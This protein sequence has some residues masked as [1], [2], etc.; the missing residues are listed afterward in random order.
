M[1]QR[2]TGLIAA[3]LLAVAGLSQPPV[4]AQTITGVVSGTVVDASGAAVPR[5]PV[6]LVNSG[7]GLRQSATS[8]ASGDFV[9]PSV[10]PGTY[11]VIVEAQGF[12]RYERTG[13]QVTAAERV[14][15]GTIQLDVGALT[16][17]VTVSGQATPVQTTSN[18]R[19]AML[20]DQQM[21]MLM[22][23]GRD[24]MGLMKTLP[25]VVPINDPTVLQQTSAPNAVNGVRG[26][27]T[28]QTVDGMVG[29]DPSSTNSSFTPVSMDAVAE[30]KVLLTNYQ[31]EYGRSAGAIINAVT[32]SG[33][34]AFHGTLYDYVRNEDLNANEF[35]ANRNGVKR[36]LYRYNVAGY[37]IGGP[38][39]IP[40]KFTRWKDKLFFFVAQEFVNLTAP[41]SLQQVTVP[42][43]LERQGDF[44]QTLDVSGKL[45]PITD[46]LSKAVFPGNLVP[47]N[48]IDP[49]GQKLLQVFPSPNITDR[50][51]TKGNY[52]Y[53]FLESIPG[54]RRFDTYRGDYNPVDKLRLYYR[55]SVFRRFD[56]GY[57]VAASG[58]AW[59][60]VKGFDKYDSNAGQ[61]HATYTI[62]STLVL[63]GSFGYYHFQEPAGPYNNNADIIDRQKIGLA[64]GQFYPQYNQYNIVPSMS[65]G[66]GTIA[67]P[68]SVSFDI[69][70]PKKGA[71]TLFTWT[72]SVTKIWGSHQI[73]AGIFLERDRMFKG[74]RGAN[75]G[76]F[77]FSRDVNNP[78]DTN[79]AYSTALLGYFR[80]YTESTSRPGPDMRSTLFEWYLQDSWRVNRKLTLDYG[81]RFGAYT[82]LWTPNLQA[83][84][85]DPSI[86][87]RSQAPLLFQP[88]LN[89]Q[90][91][92][93]ALNPLTGQYFPAVQIGLIVP[94]SGNLTNGL[95]VEG[96]SG[97]PKGFVEN[98][99]PTLAPRFGFA[100]DVFGD[101]KTA[102]RG[103][104]GF[105]YSPIVP[106]TNIG[107]SGT[108]A[109]QVN[110]PFQYNPVQYYGSLSTLFNTQGVIAPSTICGLSRQNMNQANYNFSFGVQ[111]D[112]GFR[113]VL[114]VA[115]VGALGR[116]LLQ[117][118]NLNTV[119][120]GTH[121]TNI[122]PTTK[123]A[124]AD[125]FVRPF[126]GYATINLFE[127]Y[128]NSSY[129]SMQVQAN[130]RFSK[131]LQFG[132]VWTWS[133]FM[134]Y[135]DSDGSVVA[136]YLDR[137]VWNYGKAGLDRTHIVSINLLYDVPKASHLL[138]SV[139][140]RLVL[141][142]WQV[143]AVASFIDGA[144]TGIG[145]SL[146]NGAD[147][148]G[149]GDGSRV[150]VTGNAVLDKGQRSIYQY[151]NTGAFQAP[152]VGTI[153]N[154]PKDVFRGPGINNWDLS[155]FKN[156]RFKDRAGLQLRW[157][158]YNA[159]NHAS[160]QGVNTSASFA[161]PG[162]TSQLNG[163]FGQLT[164]TNGQP[165][166]M[167]GS[168]RITF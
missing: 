9:F 2:R 18:E 20:N 98:L 92:R 83:S 141:D 166:A 61:L 106:G 40:G 58:P 97:V 113:T 143:A 65:F 14:N 57:A 167:Q 60:L 162:A 66:G 146:L 140:T 126:P 128:S 160:F 86:Y 138:N 8:S 144:P 153:G 25:G 49:N 93:S 53:N 73:K 155:F 67:N 129:H 105:F 34:S 47:Q 122:D 165:R 12:K 69:R 148:T 31:A 164:S 55:E 77:D 13:V 22:A 30:V 151:F 142:N 35:F 111:R 36:P 68:A 112:I 16:E 74:F 4:W 124:L 91:V 11:S 41:G 149:G 75:N 104:V 103:G 23:R 1:K 159:F 125:N 85:F 44:S 96:A 39:A 137:R 28:T 127:P 168:L 21:N 15:A 7:I 78:F 135:V 95:L 102:I 71:T 110:P 45:V 63:E 100:Y 17:S 5:A 145:Y 46:P 80:T 101:G 51:I 76:S 123:T 109:V 81:L 79:Y 94:N 108:Y 37:T 132:A 26:G 139:V 10:Q 33:T 133:K 64:L 84:S 119:P 158:M 70:W 6:T 32:K 117:S 72:E 42:T 136:S 147:V 19:S 157:E 116:H 88:A 154:A 82:P 107:S 43:A 115:Y 152:V 59:G 130:R 24:Y 90:G 163:Q 48:R 3:S 131:G 150:V 38:F 99:S 134:D 161:A 118:V 50:S 52:N 54:T 89:P 121:F 156:F 62:S 56:Q 27:L 29:N 120:Y 114:D 87:N